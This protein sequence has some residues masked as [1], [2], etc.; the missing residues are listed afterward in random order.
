MASFEALV[1]ICAK[2]V[3]SSA[4]ETNWSNVDFILNKRRTKL[5]NERV[6]KLLAIYSNNRVARSLQAR[7]GDEAYCNWAAPDAQ[8]AYLSGSSDEDEEP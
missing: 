8:D 4:C 6:R 2:S 3:A 5:K 1:R 7:T